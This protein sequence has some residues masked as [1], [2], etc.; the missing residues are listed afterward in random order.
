MIERR[1]LKG[2][3]LS[4]YRWLGALSYAYAFAHQSAL[5]ILNVEKTD[6]YE[7][8]ICAEYGII[9]ESEKWQNGGILRAILEGSTIL[10]QY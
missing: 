10:E 1:Q 9:T 2:Y 3:S 8:S 5:A 4:W 6:N 7:K